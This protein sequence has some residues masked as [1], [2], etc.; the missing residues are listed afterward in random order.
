MLAKKL[1]VTYKEKC[2][3]GIMAHSNNYTKPCLKS[4][5]IHLWRSF[6]LSSLRHHIAHI[7][8][9]QYETA[10]EASQF[11]SFAQGLGLR[12]WCCNVSHRKYLC[13]TKN[14]NT[15]HWPSDG[16]KQPHRVQSFWWSKLLH[17]LIIY[18]AFYPKKNLVQSRW[19][20]QQ[21]TTKS[22]VIRSLSLS[23]SLFP[24]VAASQTG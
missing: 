3:E 15:R 17:R 14:T 18:E 4:T 5:P 2:L 9:N 1:L 22:D 6:Y 24:S 23:D 21:Q 12:L 13:E 8:Q 11:H 20:L 7:T 10:L 19:S 16:P